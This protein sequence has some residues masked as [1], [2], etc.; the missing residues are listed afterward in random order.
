ME[1]LT[2]LRRAVGTRP[3]IVVGAC[4]LIR[5]GEGRVLLHRRRDSGTWD[6]IGGSMEP[7][8]TFEQ[9]ARREVREEIGVE[10]GDLEQLHTYAGPD[11][12]HVY[13]DGNQTYHVG[14]AF[15]TH[16]V[17]GTLRP[18]SREVIEVGYFALD[19]LPDP[20]ER[21]ARVLVERLRGGGLGDSGIQTHGESVTPGTR[22][23]G[24]VQLQAT[25]DQ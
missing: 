11:F 16:A 12:F 18:D 7:E 8:E 10:L 22:G 19:A 15:Q 23:D 1:Y 14:V 3:L 17:F 13:P 21:G 4:V 25:P 2:E 9:T 24:V 6:V 5:D 20:L